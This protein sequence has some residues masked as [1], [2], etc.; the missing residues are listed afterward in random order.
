MSISMKQDLV[1]WCSGLSAVIHTCFKNDQCL[2]K[3]ERKD[4]G[5]WI[6]T[7]AVGAY[8]L[9]KINQTFSIK[10]LVTKFLVNIK[11]EGYAPSH[12]YY[13]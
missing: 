7:F 5:K 9:V 4:E 3:N 12:S 2:T 13:S 10:I 8:I 1:S 6:F 11:C